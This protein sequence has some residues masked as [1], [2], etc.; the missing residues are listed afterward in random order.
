MPSDARSSDA[1][2]SDYPTRIKQFRGRLGLTQTELAARLGVSFVTVNRWE[3]GQTKPSPL[4]WSQILKFDEDDST[5]SEAQAEPVG[6]PVIDFT[7]SADVVRVLAEGERLSFGHM[8]NPAFATEVSQ[9]DP[10]PHQRIAVYEHMLKQFPLRFLL[11]DDAGAGKTIMSGLFI[12]EGKARRLIKRVL[13]IAPAGLIGNWKNELATL[14]SL[15][16]RI[17]TGADAKNSNPFMGDDSDCII[18]SVD[19]LAGTKMFARLKE[20]GVV[21]YDLVIFDEAHKLSADRGNDLRVRKTDRYRLAEALAGV[22]GL[23]EAWTLPWAAHHLLLLTA[24]PHQGKDYP[25]Y[26]LWR[27]LEPE[28]LSTPEAFDEYPPERRVAHFIRR[29]KEEMVHLNG[30][31]LYPKR[32]SDTLGYDLTQGPIS[33]Q[34]LYDETT[35]YMRHV[36]NRAKLLNRSAARLAMSVL[37]RRLAS[38]TYAL[39]RSFERRIEKLTD[40]IRQVQEGKLTEEQILILQRRMAEDDDVLDTKTAD[41][42]GTI[43]GREEGEVSEERLLGRRYRRLVDRPGCRART[44]HEAPRPR[45]EGLRRWGP[46]RNSTSSARCSPVRKFVGEKFIIFTEHRDTLDYLVHRLGG[47]GYTGQ[48]AQIHGGMDYKDR[49]VQVE[50][51]RLPH[52][53][54]GA[55]F[56]ICTDAAAEGINLQFCWIMIN[57]DV[58]WNPARLEQRMGRIHRYG[59]KHDPVQI[60]NL[61]APKTREGLVIQT[62]LNKLETIR[63][64]LGTEKVFD[65]IGRLFEGVSLKTVHGA[66]GSGRCRDRGARTGGPADQGAGR[67]PGRQRENALRRWRRRCPPASPPARRPGTGGLLPPA[68]RLRSPLRRERRPAGRHPD[69]GRSRWLLF[70]PPD[71][72]RRGRSAGF[73]RW[74]STRPSS[75]TA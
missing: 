31:P 56:M 69:R 12:R 6:P 9:I 58:P 57:F 62:L 18:V 42:E 60:V 68:A 59:Q 61:V 13:I 49:Q 25:Y 26:A 8:F 19:T 41:E 46:S 67:G 66:G 74:K 11:A 1:L 17:V 24:T 35:D 70:V 43:D 51:F 75:G 22:G 72:Q 36:Y 64:S 5:R 34:T 55:R 44:G 45:A 53:D 28:V 3:N 15:Q 48:I 32:I 30:K 54:G 16:F 71:D 40:L 10:L 27:L 14:F 4:A 29:T 50:R 39:L 21:P 7:G 73:T 65:S 33:E 47:M 63:D 38:S 20:P 52:E 37:Q 2:P 23:D